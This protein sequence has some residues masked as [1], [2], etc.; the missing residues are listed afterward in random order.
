MITSS[1]GNWW[2]LVKKELKDAFGSPL[3]YILA[4]LFSL[5]TGWLFFNYL[6]ASKELS[7]QTLTQSVFINIF[8]NMN[9]IFIFLAPLL[10]MKTFAEEKKQH[11]LELLLTSHLS[12]LQIIMAKITSCFVQAFFLIALT[13]I[14]PIILSI[15]GYGHWGVVSTSYVG[16]LLCIWCYLSVG[17]FAS[18]LTE[19][20]IVAALLTFSILLGLMLF[21][22]TGNATDSR[23]LSE[24]LQYI[25]L[26]AHFES[27]VKGAIMSFDIFYFVSFSGFFVYLTHLSLDTRRW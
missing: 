27:F 16:I 3:V 24:I 22:L 11:T 6:I 7:E 4:A 15:S 2:L 23:I 18:S 17:V 20:Q 26:S 25:S 5:I 9:F 10:T 1:T 14:F 12:H 8:G 19:N 13:L 21:V